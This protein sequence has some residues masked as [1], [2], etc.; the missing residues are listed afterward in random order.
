MET[1]QTV[2]T[3][4]LTNVA[5]GVIALL[6]AYAMS[7]VKTAIAKAKTQTAQIKD[8]EAR[9]LFTN[10]LE[11]VN[12]LVGV[13]VGA[14]EQTTASTLRIAVKAGTSDRTELV[15]LGKQAFNEVKAAITPEAQRII[16]DNLGNFD[17]YLEKLIENAVRKV[18]QEE[19][20]I[21][22][23]GELLTTNE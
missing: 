20:Y 8:E 23:P 15:N 6:S 10:A 9:K 17:L 12:E 14:I 21:T 22:L 3:D 1:I 19:P 7:F 2:A 18:K 5:L 13:T 4:V 11:N 16:T